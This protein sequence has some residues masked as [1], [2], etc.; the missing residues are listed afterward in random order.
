MIRGFCLPVD[1]S[2][3]TSTS[4][5][6]ANCRGSLQP[7]V[8]STF[9]ITYDAATRCWLPCACS[10]NYALA[11]NLAPLPGKVTGMV[12]TLRIAPHPAAKTVPNL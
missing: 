1:V 10:P 5:F 3:L 8:T 11:L 4:L 2:K 6:L 9:T 7:F 12:Q